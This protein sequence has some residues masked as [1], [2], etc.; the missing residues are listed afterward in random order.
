MLGRLEKIF[1]VQT[2]PKS[3]CYLLPPGPGR[4]ETSI[5]PFLLPLSQMAL[6]RKPYKEIMPNITDK[7]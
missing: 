6:P 1:G 5:H 4:W 7:E 2:F 3:Q